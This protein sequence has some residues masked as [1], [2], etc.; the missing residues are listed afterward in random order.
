MGKGIENRQPITN[1]NN[2]K[3]FIV[4]HSSHHPQWVKDFYSF[5]SEH[6]R[7]KILSELP[8]KNVIF[9]KVGRPFDLNFVHVNV[10]YNESERVEITSMEND[11]THYLNKN[12]FRVKWYER[13]NK[14]NICAM[15]KDNKNLKTSIENVSHC[16][17][18]YTPNVSQIGLDWI[19]LTTTH[20]LQDILAVLHK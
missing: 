8:R 14:N 3:W 1:R 20:V 19:C 6:S 5:T 13:N 2:I 18:T 7:L 10:N 9:T 11:S 4:A 17:N 12:C 15:Y 16:D